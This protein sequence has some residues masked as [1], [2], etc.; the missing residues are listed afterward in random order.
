MKNKNA[1]H[2]PTTTATADSIVRN[3]SMNDESDVGMTKS[4]VSKSDENLDVMRPLSVTSKKDSG[5]PITCESH[6]RRT[7]MTRSL[8]D[9]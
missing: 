2:V 3:A 7:S 4:M 1:G 8:G 5:A 9:T 6:P